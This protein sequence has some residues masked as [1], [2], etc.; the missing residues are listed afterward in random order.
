MA[1]GRVGSGNAACRVG[2]RCTGGLV[3]LADRGERAYKAGDLRALR[4]WLLVTLAL[5][6]AFLVNQ[7]L[8]YVVGL[9]FGIGTDVYGSSY[10]LLTGLHTSTWPWA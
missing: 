3:V 1:A 10:W 2:Y 8:D 9:S 7:L 4:R 6:G 5:G